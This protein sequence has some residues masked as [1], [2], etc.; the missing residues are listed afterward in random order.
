MIVNTKRNVWDVRRQIESHVTCKN[1]VLKA[2]FE[3]Q[4]I[5]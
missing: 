1:T 5:R 3:N 4:R 2:I